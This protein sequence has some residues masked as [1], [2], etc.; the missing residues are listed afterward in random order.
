MSSIVTPLV[1][2]MMPAFNVES[3][4]P[5]ALDSLVAQ[6][7]ENWEA[8]VVDD[9]SRDRTVDIIR[10]YATQEPRI[11]PVF[12]QHGGRGIARNRALHHCRGELVA[13][14]DADDIAVSDRLEKQVAFLSAHP[15]F[16]AVSGQCV[17]FSD[18]PA[19][20]PRKLMPWPTDP[21]EIAR[22]LVRGRMKILNGGSMI[23]KSIFDQFGGYRAEL[24]RAQ[25]YEFFRR[26][27]LAGVRL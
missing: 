19:L 25:D 1:S 21:E 7:Y 27:A 18:T 20:D 24:K 6:S 11:R 15:D 12:A 4:L 22:A 13:L 26:L 17:S 16:G 9:G 23:R 8:V 10:S 3:Y 14:L 5:A 2:V